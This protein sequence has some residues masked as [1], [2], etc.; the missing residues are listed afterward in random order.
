MIS[1]DQ[2]FLLNDNRAYVIKPKFYVNN[3]YYV[4]KKCG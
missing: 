4:T 3:L 2:G 1:E